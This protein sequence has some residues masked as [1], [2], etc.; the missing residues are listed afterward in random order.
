MWNLHDKHHL[1][2]FSFGIYWQLFGQTAW[3]SRHITVNTNSPASWLLMLYIQTFWVNTNIK[4]A[5][6]I[7]IWL[8]TNYNDICKKAQTIFQT[9]SITL[10]YA[11]S[12]TAGEQCYKPFADLQ[13]CYH[14][15]KLFVSF[16]WCGLEYYSKLPDRNGLQMRKYGRRWQLHPT[17][18]S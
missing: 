13:P 10:K 5:N 17:A 7:M 11:I 15:C 1:C 2:S 16:N 3:Q 4:D 6:S 8:Y 12:N 18:S 9:M 14:T